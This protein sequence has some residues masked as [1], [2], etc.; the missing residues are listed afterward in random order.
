MVFYRRH[1]F[2]IVTHDLF[3]RAFVLAGLTFSGSPG[4]IVVQACFKV[5]LRSTKSGK[6]SFL[7]RQQSLFGT[8]LDA[9]KIGAK[10]A[11]HVVRI[12]HRAVE[13][14]NIE[15]ATMGAGNNAIPAGCAGFSE[16]YRVR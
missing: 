9:R 11:G 2:A 8:G 13:V 6:L 1:A 4:S 16:S 12:Q 14:G 10:M 15:D 3:H 5:D 7:Q